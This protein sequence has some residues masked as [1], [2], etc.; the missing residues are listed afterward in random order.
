MQMEA[1]MAHNLTKMQEICNAVS[2]D[3]SS[4]CTWKE[5]GVNSVQMV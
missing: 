2:S 3:G 5:H 1:K 4:K